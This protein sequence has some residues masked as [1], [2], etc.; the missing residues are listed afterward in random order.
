MEVQYIGLAAMNVCI[1]VPVCAVGIK[2]FTKVSSV[3]HMKS[4]ALK[5]L[6]VSTAVTCLR[7]YSSKR[8]VVCSLMVALCGLDTEAVDMVSGNTVTVCVAKLIGILL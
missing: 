1:S 4:V 2:A 3:E 7:L 5:Q 6:V 8:S